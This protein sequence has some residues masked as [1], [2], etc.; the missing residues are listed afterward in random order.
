M[1][2]RRRFS[3][4][5][6]SIL[7]GGDILVASDGRKITVIAADQAVSKVTAKTAQA[8][9][10]AAYH[11][12]NRHVP[13]QIEASWLIFERDAVLKDMLLGLGDIEVED[14]DAPLSLRRVPMVVDI[15]T[16]MIT[17]GE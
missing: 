4:P 9:T 8:L 11:L 6:G 1:G 10:R 2:K 3:C 17:D 16:G 15:I 7:R 12:G 5:V 14:L 13:L